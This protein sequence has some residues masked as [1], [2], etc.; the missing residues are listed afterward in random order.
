MLLDVWY[1][2]ER[3]S[4]SGSLPV[5]MTVHGGGYI[6]GN[7]SIELP[8]NSYWAERGFVAFAVEYR[9]AKHKGVYPRSLMHWQPHHARPRARWKPPISAL[10][11]AVR[12]VKAAL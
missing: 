12:D 7:K 9:V 11:P 2:S 3:P 1:P 4:N 8:P 10:Y 6:K 5:V